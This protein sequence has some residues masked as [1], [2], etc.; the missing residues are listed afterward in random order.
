MAENISYLKYM[1]LHI[2]ES[3]QIPNRIKGST[4]RHIGCLTVETM[5]NES[6]RR[7]PV[8]PVQGEPQ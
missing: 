3:H 8:P 5:N 1:N 7:E 4:L 6:S 2:Q